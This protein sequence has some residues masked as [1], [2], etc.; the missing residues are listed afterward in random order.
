M[1]IR[2]LAKL[3]GVDCDFLQEIVHVDAGSDD[4]I[5]E[6]VYRLLGERLIWGWAKEEE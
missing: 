6:A 1:K 5:D 2:V 4:D 3:V